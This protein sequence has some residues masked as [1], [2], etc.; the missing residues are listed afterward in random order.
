MRVST[1]YG[2]VV[3]F[4][5]GGQNMNSFMK[6]ES[7]KNNIKEVIDHINKSKLKGMKV[8]LSELEYDEYKNSLLS[9]S[10]INEYSEL[11]FQN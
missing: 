4:E 6:E 11:H 2:V 5:N 3:Q 7:A 8:Y 10:L 9:S 1:L